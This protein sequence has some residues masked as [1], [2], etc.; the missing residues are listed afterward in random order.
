MEMATKYGKVLFL[1]LEEDHRDST[2]LSNKKEDIIV[3]KDIHRDGASNH[4]SHRMTDAGFEMNGT[5]CAKT[6]MT[7]MES[8]RMSPGTKVA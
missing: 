7:G 1:L 6:R 2:A 3:G 4:R 5:I 8:T